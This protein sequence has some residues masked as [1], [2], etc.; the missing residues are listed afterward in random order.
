MFE[1]LQDILTCLSNAIP[2]IA[3]VSAQVFHMCAENEALSIFLGLGIL[4]VAASAVGKLG[5]S[6]R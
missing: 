3:T 4:E 5:H 2:T 1:I 6:R